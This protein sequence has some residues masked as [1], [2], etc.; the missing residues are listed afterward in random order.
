M[1]GRIFLLYALFL[2]GRTEARMSAGFNS[3]WPLI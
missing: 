2:L 1:M 3:A